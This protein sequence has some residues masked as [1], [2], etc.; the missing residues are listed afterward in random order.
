MHSCAV[1]HCVLLWVVL[2]F[3]VACLRCADSVSASS[4]LATVGGTQF[5]IRGSNLGLHP[6]PIVVRYENRV[7]GFRARS[8]ST[9]PN[10]CQVLSPGT[11][12]RCPSVAGLGVN[13]TFSVSVDR[14][15][16]PFSKDMLSYAAPVISSVD[17][18]GSSFTSTQVGPQRARCLRCICRVVHSVCAL[19][20]AGVTRIV[21]PFVVARV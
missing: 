8:H 21:K 15:Q 1:L 7:S 4:A 18:P 2:N 12:I 9:L 13:Y 6:T 5:L 3:F 19:D 14:G 20:M 17:G 10:E 16:S 11:L